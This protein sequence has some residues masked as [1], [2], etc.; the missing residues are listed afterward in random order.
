MRS[1]N[2]LEIGY[3]GTPDALVSTDFCALPSPH[4][5]TEGKD[6]AEPESGGS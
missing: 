2:H 6:G 3:F 5:A 4:H 1:R